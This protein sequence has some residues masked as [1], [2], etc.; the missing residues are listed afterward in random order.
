MTVGILVAGVVVSAV[1]FT[2][3]RG[4]VQHDN[5]L[6]LR[7]EASQASLVL[8]PY[9]AQPQ[10]EIANLASLVTTSG[11]DAAAWDKS[12]A[13]AAAQSAASAVALV[14]LVGGNLQVVTSTGTPHAPFGSGADA[15]LVAA[16]DAGHLPY[17][18]AYSAGGQRFIGQLS[19]P[20]ALPKGYALYTESRALSAPISLATLPGHPFADIEGALYV[21]REAPQDLVFTTTSRLPLR[22]QRAVTVV[23]DSEAFASSR[24]EISS[25]VGSVSSQGN[26]VLVI[27]A[28]TS[29]IGTASDRLPWVLLGGLLLSSLAVAVLFEISGRRRGRA[30][31]V[32]AELEERNSMLDVAI[33]EQERTHARFAA[34]VRSSS[35]LTTVVDAEGIILYQSPSSTGL[36]GWDPDQLV[37]TSFT[38]LVRPDDRLVWHRSMTYVV[39]EPDTQRSATWHLTTVDGADVSVETRITNLLDDPAVFGIVLNSRDVTE[40]VRLEE[41]LRHQAF[42]DSLTG[43]ANR[44][45]FQDRLVHAAARLERTGEPISV[46]F[47][48]LDDFKSVNDGRGHYTGDEVLRSVGD[49]LRQTVRA[50]D[51]LAR[52]GGDEFAVLLEGADEATAVTTAG[53]VL[54][55]LQR[56]FPVAGTEA[57]I[58]ASI[59]IVSPSEAPIDADDLLRDADIAM[60]AAKSAGKDQWAVFRPSLYDKVINRLQLETDLSRAIDNDELAVQYQPVVDL[61]SGQVRGIE[62]LMRWRHPYRGTVMPGDFIPIAES[63]GLIVP[64]GRWLLNRACHD[65]RRLQVEAR[66]PDLRLAVNLSARQLDDEDLVDDVQVALLTS[67]LRPEF[68]TLEITE[69]VFMANPDRSVRVL[70]QLRGLGVKMSIDDFGT[71]YSS[72]SYLQRLPVDELKIDRSFVVDASAAGDTTALV[73]TIVRLAE[74]FGLET[75]AEGVETEE[76]LHRLR[77]AGCRLAQG[78]LFAHPSDIDETS[79]LLVSAASHSAGGRGGERGAGGTRVG[80]G[81]VRQLSRG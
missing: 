68:L 29:L 70:E 35:D 63:T 56:P 52:L 26:L 80:P 7:Q 6:L 57:G 78:F 60:Y 73:D 25:K 46:L 38:G 33:A 12:A 55:A 24:S 64:M 51:T 32:A 28:T 75:V 31:A 27:K 62:A 48:D 36:L 17:D 21:G 54:E 14:Q 66:R 74:D 5:E 30:V 69:S 65:V 76:Q 49:R 1:V 45:L 22:G 13:T 11:V 10:P 79:R 81:E 34:M 16:V 40:R 8:G 20:A 42:H 4:S 23:N 58:R 19:T 43:L 37:G 77:R 61:R 50:G 3:A 44:A 72:L 15:T 41:E 2:L 59:G 67:G 9:V 47:L 18:V 39:Q 53:R 71:G